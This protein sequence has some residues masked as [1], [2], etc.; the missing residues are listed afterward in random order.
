MSLPF[1]V[2]ASTRKRSSRGR[3]LYRGASPWV[4]PP[5]THS[6]GSG[7]PRTTEA[8]GV[9]ARSRCREAGAVGEAVHSAHAR[10]GAAAAP[11][12]RL[13]RVAHAAIGQPARVAL[14]QA[15]VPGQVQLP[16]RGQ[17][18]TLAAA[19][20]TRAGQGQPAGWAHVENFACGKAREGVSRGLRGLEDPTLE[21]S[22][23]VGLTPNSPDLTENAAL[24]SF[25]R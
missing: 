11:T 24:A 2:S 21:P 12:R 20:G 18:G 23:E 6:P 14:V 13:D 9:E 19:L 5:G 25:Y 16:H 3:G 15:L 17:R 1:P 22:Q 7:L 4:W 8:V 10:G